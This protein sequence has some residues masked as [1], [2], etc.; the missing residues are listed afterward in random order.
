[1]YKVIDDTKT[2]IFL[3]PIPRWITHYGFGAIIVLLVVLIG[4]ATF[5]KYPT[6]IILTVTITKTT[7]AAQ[8]DFETYQKLK[9]AQ[10]I[11]IN[12]PFAQIKGMLIKSSGYAQNTQLVVPIIVVDSIIQKLPFK[13]KIVC[14]G[15][16]TIENKSLLAR[17]IK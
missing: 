4:V 5:I 12:T 10:E 17:I 13:D 15:E 8:T 7:A 11:S 2:D 1:M 3:N 9:S 6:S 16:V 14:K